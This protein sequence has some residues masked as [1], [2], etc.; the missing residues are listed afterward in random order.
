M[1]DSALERKL[2]VYLRDDLVGR[3]WLDDR[4]RFVF[5]YDPAWLKRKSPVPLSLS[6]PLKNESYLDDAARPFFSN[7]LPEAGVR[8]ALA[9]RLKISEQNEFDLLREIGG[10]CAGAVSVLPEGS[11][12]SVSPGYREIGE[13]EL[14]RIVKELP[15]RPFLVGDRGLRLSLAGAQSKLPVYLE[16][17]RVFL[18][19]GNAPS[20]HILKPP[21]PGIEE[22]VEN[23]E[24]CMMLAERM[25]LTVPKARIRQGHDR[26]YIVERYD[27]ER[28]QG[29]EILRLHQ[30]DFCQA[31]GILPEQKYEAEGGPSLERCFALLKEQS[32]SPASDQK[33]FLFWVVFNALIGNADA[34][35]KNLAIL[36]TPRGPRLAPFYDLISTL[37]YPDLSSRLAM[38]IGG[39]NRLNWI[40][41]RHWEKFS[42]EV[43]IKARWTLTMVRYI[44]QRV[45]SLTDS[46]AAE[47]TETYGRS[48]TVEKVVQLIKKTASRFAGST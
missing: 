26:L 28:N 34:H 21:I 14:H 40:Q 33:A 31:L 18:A 38:R 24:F 4:R 15:R 5:Q 35:A 10:E 41:Q 25:G 37:V 13:E 42:R 7:L 16:G 11:S 3:L 12:P 45:S 19:T 39:E 36:Y 48:A 22:S 1:R 43:G 29:G 47:F 27:R 6:L 17:N 32:A 46:V 2:D 30:E 23:E 9:R 8:Q 44:S 20:T